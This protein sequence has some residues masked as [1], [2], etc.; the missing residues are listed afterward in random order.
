MTNGDEAPPAPLGRRSV[1]ASLLTLAA[2]GGGSNDGAPP[3]PPPPINSVTS[4]PVTAFAAPWS[5]A[6]LPDGR[7]LVTERVYDNVS[8]PGNFWLVTQAGAKS[9]LGPLPPNFG[10]LDI[11]L[12]PLFASNQTI[13]LTFLEPGGPDEPRVGR[14]IA[15]P[16]RSPYGLA[17]ATVS[18]IF[19]ADGSGQLA[20]FDVIWRQT[21]KIVSFP[22]SGEP[23]GKMAFSPD[24]KYLFV[25]AGDRQELDVSF[26]FSLNNTLGKIIRLY[27]DG[28]VPSDNPFATQ[29]GAL[30]EIWTIG[31][32]NPYG[33][34]F[35][36]NGLLWEHENGPM[37]GDELNLIQPGSNYGWPAV[38][39]G[40]DYLGN[41]YPEPAPG[42]GYAPAAYVWT[43]AIAPSGMI[44]YSGQMFAAWKGDAIITGLQSHGLVRVDFQG[45]PRPRRNASRSA[46][47]CANWSSGPTARSG[48]WRMR[49]Q[50]VCSSWRRC[51]DGLRPR[52]SKIRCYSPRPC[53]ISVRA[54]RLSSV[55][56]AALL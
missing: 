4:N 48:S 31:H 13:Y 35:D 44:F 27:L 5:M 12:H 18:L 41:K 1:I 43:P 6:F 56:R 42:D 19:N 51:P 2:C 23:G 8:V 16:T 20:N 36:H 53:G 50:A 52:V 29:P 49:R 45:R 24:R 47:V 11:A 7:L 3:S 40:S 34:A 15:D 33:L 14:D 9:Q 28:S 55:G 22:G 17:L 46:L 37:G 30:P 10:V 54:G 26:L 39:Y 32:R 25:T 21:P 38:S